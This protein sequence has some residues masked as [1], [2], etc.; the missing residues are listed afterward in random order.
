MAEKG[1]KKPAKKHAG[2]RPTNFK[3]EFKAQVVVLAEKGFT[4]IEIGKMFGV[5]KT[6]INTWK[7]KY[8][9]F[10]TSIK[11]GKKVA[12]E[13]V[14]RALYQRAI[15][16]SHPDVHISNHQGKII[17]TSIIKHYPPDVAAGFI[18][19]KNRKPNEWK[20]K[21]EITGNDGGPIQISIVD[22]GNIDDTK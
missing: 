12:D 22:F 21:K 16:Y 5:T 9:E 1:K 14:E 2:G 18:W 10:L 7:K 3:P 11:K 6:T 15:G 20:D 19:L 17:I 8:P 13:K 4:D